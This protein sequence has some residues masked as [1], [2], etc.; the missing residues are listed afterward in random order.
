MQSTRLLRF[1]QLKEMTG[2]SRT[3]VWRM[4]KAGTFP[5]HR[6]IS[7]RMVCWVENEVLEWMQALNKNHLDIN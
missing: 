4:E 2:L 3:T 1:P 6:N 7:P 5:Q